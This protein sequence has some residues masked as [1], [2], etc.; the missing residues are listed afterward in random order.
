M[1]ISVPISVKKNSDNISAILM[2]ILVQILEKIS[3]IISV[4]ILIRECE[5]LPNRQNIGYIYSHIFGFC[6]GHNSLSV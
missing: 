2:R 1:Q 6:R 5:I 4:I 3:V